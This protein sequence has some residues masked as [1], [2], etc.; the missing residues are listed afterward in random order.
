M[1]IEKILRSQGW[2]S[3]IYP[4]II[5]CCCRSISYKSLCA[6]QITLRFIRRH[7]LLS[8][9]QWKWYSGV[10]FTKGP[11]LFLLFLWGIHTK[12]APNF[13]ANK[14][15][16]HWREP[17]WLFFYINSDLDL[18]PDLWPRPLVILTL[19]TID[20][21]RQTDRRRR[22]RAHRAWAQVGSKN[23]N[24]VYLLGIYLQH[25]LKTVVNL[26]A[27]SN[28]ETKKQFITHFNTLFRQKV[29]NQLFFFFQNQPKT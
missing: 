21:D 3:K 18:W 27:L 20:I 25:C 22:I 12:S 15:T 8:R 6:F 23:I 7:E 14:A 26:R 1:G 28:P 13:E 2:A 17:T 16:W 19:F 9:T 5:F 4:S 10:M 11:L 29:R 24:P